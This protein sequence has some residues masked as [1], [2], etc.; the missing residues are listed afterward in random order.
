MFGNGRFSSH[1]LTFRA[2]LHCRRRVGT[3]PDPGLRMHLSMVA[4]E[5]PM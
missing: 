4:Y 2:S 1:I 3:R 5:P